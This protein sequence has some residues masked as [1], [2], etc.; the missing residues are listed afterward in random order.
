MKTKSFFL[1]LLFF[2]STHSIAEPTEI[3]PDYMDAADKGVN[4]TRALTLPDGTE[5]T[6]GEFRKSTIEHAVR[7]MS[8]QFKN[9]VPLTWSVKFGALDGYGAL[10]LGPSFSEVTERTQKDDFGVMK[11]GR[12][13][14]LTLTAALTEKQTTDY[15]NYGETTF[16][17]RDDDFFFEEISENTGLPLLATVVYHELTHFYGFADTNCLGGCVPEDYSVNTTMTEMLRY[18]QENGNIALYDNMNIDARVEAGKSVDDLLLLGSEAT[19]SALSNELTSGTQTYNDKTYVEMFADPLADGSYD[20]QVGAH[21]SN[22]IQPAQL[23]RSSVAH[24]TDLGVAAYMLCDIGWC[25]GSG[26]VI[27]LSATASI[28]ENASSETETYLVVTLKNNTNTTVD[29]VVAQVRF[30]DNYPELSVDSADGCELSEGGLSCALPFGPLE[31]KE[32]L[33]SFG[34]LADSGY[35]I[36]GEIYSDDYDVDRDGFNNI[37]DATLTFTADDGGNDDG[38]GNDD[39]GNGDT[40]DGGGNDDNG[41]DDG[42]SNE[43]PSE[44]VSS[45]TSGGSTSLGF[46]LLLGL[47]SLASRFFFN[48]KQ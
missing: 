39:D 46:L 41:S 16:V 24:T 28:N 43:G 27:D 21:V 34:T 15:D 19:Q 17:D 25:R 30:D 3:V 5:T 26:E 11:E 32:I 38:G 4:D 9:D 1:S 23:M 47:S 7:A 6:V 37:L 14:P 13:Y 35:Q 29:N 31:E 12:H 45:D 18:H 10:T 33:L 22:N 42:T 48:T 36:A 8:L 2:I 40:D 20:P 44:N